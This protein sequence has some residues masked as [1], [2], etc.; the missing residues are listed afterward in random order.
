MSISR[1]QGIFS[2]QSDGFIIGGKRIHKQLDLTNFVTQLTI[3]LYDRSWYCM[4]LADKRDMK[5]VFVFSETPNKMYNDGLYCTTLGSCII[6]AEA[7]H[8]S[9]RYAG[10]NVCGT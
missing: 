1:N 5:M 8:V 9:D 10:S 3:Q 7:Q 6:V 4:Q 2:I